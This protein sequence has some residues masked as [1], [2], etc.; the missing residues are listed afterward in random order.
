MVFATQNEQKE[1]CY[2]CSFPVPDIPLVNEYGYEDLQHRKSKSRLV[3]HE[4]RSHRNMDSTSRRHHSWPCLN[5]R[6]S[7]T[8]ADLIPCDDGTYVE[9]QLRQRRPNFLRLR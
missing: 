3:P 6:E 7:T 1:S 4:D 2:A 9:F 8:C 5:V